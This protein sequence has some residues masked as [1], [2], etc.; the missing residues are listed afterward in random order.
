MLL[1]RAGKSISFHSIF[2]FFIKVSDRA[3]YVHKKA[4]WCF[5]LLVKLTKMQSAAGETKCICYKGMPTILSNSQCKYTAHWYWQDSIL[6]S[7]LWWR[8]APSKCK[9]RRY[10]SVIFNV[11]AFKTAVYKLN[12]I[13]AGMVTWRAVTCHHTCMPYQVSHFLFIMIIVLLD[14]QLLLPQALYFLIFLVFLG[15]LTTEVNQENCF[16]LLLLSLIFSSVN[17]II[18]FGGTLLWVSMQ[19]YRQS[20]L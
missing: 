11:L 6:L 8:Q 18:D 17:L 13:M 16:C 1:F 4:A 15:F 2:L 12:W 10:N 7:R 5:F 20:F 14:T 19:Y 3:N 9:K